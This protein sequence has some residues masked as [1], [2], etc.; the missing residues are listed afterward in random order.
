QCPGNRDALPL[1]LVLDPEFLLLDE[2]TSALDLSVQAQV[3]ELLRE[4][5]RRHGLTYLFISHDLKV[6]RALCHRVMVMKD[7]R[8]VEQGPVDDVLTQPKTDYTSE[9]V[10]AAFEVIA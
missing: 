9:L 6:V 8:I 1:A 4:L 5:Q 3:I 2:P 7:G 10:T